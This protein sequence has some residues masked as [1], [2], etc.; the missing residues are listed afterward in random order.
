[1]LHALSSYALAASYYRWQSWRLLEPSAPSTDDER[2]QPPAQQMLLP[3][4][5]FSEQLRKILP[6]SIFGASSVAVANLALLFIYPSFH[7]MIQNTTPFWTLLVMITFGK[8]SYNRWSYLAMLPVCGGG[9]ICS[10]A[11]VNVHFGGICLSISATVLRALRVLVQARVLCEDPVAPADAKK[12]KYLEVSELESNDADAKNEEEMAGLVAGD[13]SAQSRNVPVR[14]QL[15]LNS[16]A[17][18]Y[19]ASPFNATIYVVWSLL[20][21]GLEPWRLFF[22]SHLSR[23]TYVATVGSALMAAIFNLFAF[24]MVA[25]LGPLT[26]MA[27]GNLKNFLIIAVSVL[28]FHNSC[29]A[30]QIIGFLIVSAG[31][32]MNS[33]C[34]KEVTSSA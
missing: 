18:L 5:T 24:L 23:S 11:E 1:M 34:G 22:G 16:M 9:L 31:V 13:S 15:K 3:H 21:E 10:L 25:R 30:T 4:L 6:F 19:Y 7:E 8:T 2:N 26:S 28:L 12:K 29:S 20:N 33:W 32:M 27:M 17:L 14:K